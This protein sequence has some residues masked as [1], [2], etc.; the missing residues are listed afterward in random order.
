MVGT[1]NESTQ[2]YRHQPIH[3]ALQSFS[4]NGQTASSLQG[5]VIE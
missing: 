5:K 4:L 1:A 2:P 3:N